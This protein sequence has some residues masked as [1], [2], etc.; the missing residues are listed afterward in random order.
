MKRVALAL[1]ALLSACGPVPQDDSPVEEIKQAAGLPH[2]DAWVQVTLRVN[3]EYVRYLDGTIAARDPGTNHQE[4]GD[5]FMGLFNQDGATGAERYQSYGTLPVHNLRPSGPDG[6]GGPALAS[7]DYTW[8]FNARSNTRYRYSIYPICYGR[9]GDTVGGVPQ[10]VLALS[11]AF[12]SSDWFYTGGPGT[13]SPP[14][15]SPPQHSP[16]IDKNGPFYAKSYWRGVLAECNTP[17]D[18]VSLTYYD[19]HTSYTYYTCTDPVLCTNT[20]AWN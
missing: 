14:I 15:G 18:R 3:Y 6:H 20:A 5:A 10:P 7:C 4:C 12:Y 13:Y 19:T 8:T 2:P 9:V 1:F 17:E 16:L 11:H